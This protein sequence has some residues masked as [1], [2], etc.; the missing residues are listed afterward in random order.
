M[1]TLTLNRRADAVSNSRAIVDAALHVLTQ[2]PNATLGQIATAAGVH[3][4][5]VYLHFA[6]REELIL[7]AARG[8]GEQIAA[9]VAAIP[10]CDEPL[11]T[12]AT[13]VYANSSA[14]AQLHRFG[15]LPL[16]EGA[17][18]ELCATTAVVRQRIA[19]LLEDAQTR[20]HLDKRIP[21]HAG[22]HSA[23]TVQCGIFEAVAEGDLTPEEAPLIAVR[24]VLGSV[25][26]EPTVVE[27]IIAR[28]AASTSS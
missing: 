14:V 10:D 1:T 13:F 28:I 12:L 18:A 23:A 11:L 5:T 22:M 26:A 4:R 17:K 8:M 9:R 2:D 20:G 3:R 24:S 25:G 27:S 15:R 19:R 16:V 21:P 7:A 6:S